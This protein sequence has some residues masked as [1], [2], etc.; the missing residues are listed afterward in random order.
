MLLHVTAICYNHCLAFP[1]INYKV[2]PVIHPTAL[3]GL[4]K[5]TQ[6]IFLFST[7]CASMRY[8]LILLGVTTWTSRCAIQI[9]KLLTTQLF[10]TSCLS[11]LLGPNI[12]LSINVRTVHCLIGYDT[13]TL[14]TDYYSFIYYSG[15]YMFRHLCAIF[16]ERPLSL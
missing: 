12:S 9:V 1:I 15:S 4:D 8:N 2:M 11:L 14:C 7:T 6:S 10:C 16:R 13:P 5:L 3:T